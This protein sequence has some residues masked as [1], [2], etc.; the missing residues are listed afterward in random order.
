MRD[1]ITEPLWR[2]EDLGLP[3]PDSDHAVSVS[4]PLW[5]HVIG[6][7][8]KLPEVVAKLQC[9]YP[10]FLI[11]P[12]VA[13]LNETAEN[14]LA[15]KGE[16][17]V[18]FPSAAAAHRCV[19]YVRERHGIEA[20]C[21]ALDWQQLTVVVL[22]EKGREA[23]LKFWRFGGEIVS[24]RMAAAAL[25]MLVEGQGEPAAADEVLEKGRIAKEKIRR[26]LAEL[27]GQDAEN[28]FLFSWLFTAEDKQSVLCCLGTPPNCQRAF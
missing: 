21:E 28:V 16:R 2:P 18:V 1:L 4:M 25:A 10:R 15:G 27:S 17:C 8:E 14:R 24:S 26:R 9:G 20:R 11:H 3:L 5:Q 12:Q 19:S 6:Y 23:A 13:R 7:E 22:P